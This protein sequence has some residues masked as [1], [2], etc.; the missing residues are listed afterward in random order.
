LFESAQHNFR[1]AASALDLGSQF[2]AVLLLTESH[3]ANYFRV[4]G[5]ERWISHW[6]MAGDSNLP[7]SRS[8]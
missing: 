3:N 6:W 8:R 7:W 1:N 5:K 4:S 2:S